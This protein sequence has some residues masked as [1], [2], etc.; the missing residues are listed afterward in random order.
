MRTWLCAVLF[1]ILAPV[2]SAKGIQQWDA[3]PAM[4][5]QHLQ[6]PYTGRQ[7]CPMCQHGYDAG[8]LVFLPSTTPPALARD[9]AEEL[10]AASGSVGDRRFRP[11]LVFTGKAPSKA[12]LEAVKN[13]ERNWYV[14]VIPASR[15][16]EAE[17]DFQHKLDGQAWGYVFAQRRLLWSFYP[18]QTSAHWSARLRAYSNYA[19]EFLQANYAQVSPNGNP[20]SPKGRLWLAPDKI[21]SRIAFDNTSDGSAQLC[22]SQAAR[23]PGNAALIGVTAG[24][25]TRSWWAR[26]DDTGCVVVQ[27]RA[28]G[29]VLQIEQF[30][31][32]S[33]VVRS[34]IDA[35]RL[36]NGERLQVSRDVPATN[37]VSG[38][39]PIVGRT[40]DG[41]EI[42]FLGLPSQ[43]TSVARVAP[44]SEPGEALQITGIVRELSGAPRAG[45]I[46]YAYQT[47]RGGTYPISTIPG[48]RHGRLR[49]WARS[50]ADGRYT[51]QTIRPGGYPETAIP[52]HIHMHVIEP[53]RCT[54][55][56][57]DLLF[58]DDARLTADLRKRET[59]GLG[60]SGIVRPK[61][62]AR[63]GWKATRD[64]ILG[65]NIADYGRCSSSSRGAL[66]K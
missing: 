37:I 9:I 28:P 50:D 2:A 43:M 33:P 48:V 6:G 57:S 42:A 25:A 45:V 34:R 64:I 51:L 30:H 10:L 8:L 29:A 38:K 65:L 53:G 16:S 3:L 1:C 63:S 61:G 41:C 11:F 36:R 20:D 18:Y 17:R 60:G 58:A 7:V 24:P 12:L 62:N 39:E 40:C 26:T 66:S 19:M 21:D 31:T 55:F 49:G 27:G 5:V 14:G 32:L 44:A 59:S 35:G 46:V 54:F 15:L 22:V 47:D 56:I 52:Q 13:P 23:K 4:D